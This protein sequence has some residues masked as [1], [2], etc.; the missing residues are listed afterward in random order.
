[1]T[2]NG[3][4]CFNLFHLVADAH[5]ILIPPDIDR[6]CFVLVSDVHGYDHRNIRRFLGLN[7]LLEKYATF[8]EQCVV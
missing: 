8:F 2:P 1:M 7:K 5:S 6:E 4:T 3:Y